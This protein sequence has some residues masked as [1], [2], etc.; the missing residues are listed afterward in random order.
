MVFAR[1]TT[2]GQLSAASL[3]SVLNTASGIEGEVSAFA[4]SATTNRLFVSMTD[5]DDMGGIVVFEL[6][7]R[8][9]RAEKVRGKQNV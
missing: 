9:D 8:R 7:M 1:N 5:N 6:Q 3:V 2:T 4:I